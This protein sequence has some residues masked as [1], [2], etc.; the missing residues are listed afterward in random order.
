MS[1]CCW[2]LGQKP[3]VAISISISEPCVSRFEVVARL[4]STI[5]F[6]RTCL[7][8]LSIGSFSL[9]WSMQLVN[10]CWWS[11]W[12]WRPRTPFQVAA[13]NYVSSVWSPLL[14][15][16]MIVIVLELRPVS[17]GTHHPASFARVWL[18]HFTSSIVVSCPACQE[19]QG[20][21]SKGL[22]V[23]VS[24]STQRRERTVRNCMHACVDES[25]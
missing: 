11:G 17:C 20:L 1:S 19:Y 25:V 22:L 9:A 14:C 16:S 23:L 12:R 2:A 13:N 5:T 3:G 18:A 4:L 21:P 24:F 10:E 15:D 8:S 7:I 6:R